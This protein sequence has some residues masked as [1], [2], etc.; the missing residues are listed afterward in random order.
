MSYAVLQQLQYC[1]TTTKLFNHQSNKPRAQRCAAPKF[2]VKLKETHLQCKHGNP[3]T[4]HW[5]QNVLLRWNMAEPLQLRRKTPACQLHIRTKP[6]YCPLSLYSDIQNETPVS[7][8][9]WNIWLF[10]RKHISFNK[11]EQFSCIKKDLTSTII[12]QIWTGNWCFSEDICK[13]EQQW[14]IGDLCNSNKIFSNP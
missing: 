10:Q 1:T 12:Q 3:D 8:Q 6:L 5:M 11:I 13:L 14:F 2:L 7:S 4:D 9:I